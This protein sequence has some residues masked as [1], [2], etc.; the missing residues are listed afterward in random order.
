VA[1]FASKLGTRYLLLFGGTLL[2][3]IGMGATIAYAP[4]FLGDS[5]PYMVAGAF[6]V[7]LSVVAIL[8]KWQVGAVMLPALLPYE[9]IINL[10]PV[11][12]GIKAIALLT[13][14]SLALSLLRDRR[15]LERFLRLW[16]RPLTL[17]TL[18]F[19]CWVFA[20]VTWASQQ[21]AALAK[22]IT[23]TGVFA[24][25]VIVG[26]LEV[27]YLV[28]LWLTTAISSVISIPAAL[29]SSQGEAMDTG[30]RFSGE[31]IDPNEYACLLVIV[32]L[33][34]YFGLRRYKIL[35]YALAPILFFGVFASLSRTALITLVAAPML[36][37]FVRRSSVRL[38]GRTLLMY[39]LGTLA[40]AGV[41]LAIPW[42]GES[43]WERYM[44]LLQ[45]N[46]QAT[47]SGRWDI[48]RGALQVIVSHPFL[49]VGTGNFP[50]AAVDYSQYVTRLSAQGEQGGV[51]HNILLSVASELGLVGLALF[52]GIFFF[53]FKTLLPIIQRSALGTGV[54]LGLIAFTIAGMALTWEDE[55][56][57]WVLFGS[58]LSLQLQ[59][60][61]R[62]A[63][64]PGAQGNQR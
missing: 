22:M 53:A 31:A 13:L 46:N 8:L 50:Y 40:L 19:L 60:S 52:L 33:V 6:L 59:P 10:G 18:V 42:V 12:S 5:G 1:T 28:L 14:F 32:F 16:Q 55:K 62:P 43:V 57:G 41:V 39:G 63:P 26:M 51:A 11:A 30:G 35:T 64:F 29:A 24:L 37:V 36:A 49:G 25:M 3:A 58:V 15:L 45:Y 48:W 21:E 56:I 27:R 23:F 61:V 54:F 47:W 34:A 17:M 7:A 20:S 9:G 44:T 2:L 4:R 38:G